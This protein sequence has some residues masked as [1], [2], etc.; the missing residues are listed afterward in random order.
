LDWTAIATG[1]GAI[2]TAAGGVLLVVREFRRRD[3]RAYR[4]E[5]DDLSDQLHLC[6]ADFTTFRSWAFELRQRAADAG[7]EQGEPPQPR[8]LVDEIPGRRRGVVRD[9]SWIDDG[10]RRAGDGGTDQGDRDPGTAG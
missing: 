5:I 7:V 1:I 4:R 3:R 10:D 2:L 6:R 9:V 8:H